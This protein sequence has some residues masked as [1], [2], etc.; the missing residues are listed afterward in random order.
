M[1]EDEEQKSEHQEQHQDTVPTPKQRPTLPKR[2]MK[3]MSDQIEKHETHLKRKRSE[4]FLTL[5]QE[6]KRSQRRQKIELNFFFLYDYFSKIF[7][8]FFFFSERHCQLE[9]GKKK[10]N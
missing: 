6:E 3:L 8:L 4:L 2:G 1:E 7:P 5:Q 10:K 9:F